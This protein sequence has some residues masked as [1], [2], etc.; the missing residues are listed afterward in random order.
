M[1]FVG[2]FNHGFFMGMENGYSNPIL[3]QN[4]QDL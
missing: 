1:F 3:E 4:N 2:R